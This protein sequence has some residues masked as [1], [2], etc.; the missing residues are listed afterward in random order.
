MCVCL[1][2]CVSVCVYVCLQVRLPSPCGCPWWRK[3]PV[4]RI[5]ESPTGL[6]M[7]NKASSNFFFTFTSIEPDAVT[8]HPLLCN[9]VSKTY[10]RRCASDKICCARMEIAALSGS[11]TSFA[12]TSFSL[13]LSFSLLLG[14]NCTT[15]DAT[16]L[17]M[18]VFWSKAV[19]SSTLYCER[20]TGKGAR[21]W[22]KQ[23]ICEKCRCQNE[24]KFSERYP[25]TVTTSQ[26]VIGP[27]V[28][29][30]LR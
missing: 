17:V 8:H 27:S 23:R 22:L 29:L 19:R 24:I 13:V 21:G 3:T 6:L 11:S 18:H 9:V 15:C 16:Q 12:F 5:S 2:V 28:I 20:E 14:R 4:F 1:C 7:C 10:L 30:S 25:R 26:S